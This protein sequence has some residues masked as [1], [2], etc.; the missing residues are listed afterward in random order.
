MS[1]MILDVLELK[2][3][4]EFSSGYSKKIYGRNIS[5]KLKMNQKTVSNVLNKLERKHVLKFNQVGRNKYYFLN[6]YYFGIKEI[7]N[8][9]EISRKLHFLEE[10]KKMISLFRKLESRANGMMIVFGSYADGSKTGKSDLDLFII[11]KN[12]DVEDL[13]A[14]YGVKINLIKSIKSKFNENEVI[15][16]EVIRNHVVLKGVEDF[17]NLIW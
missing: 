14:E 11:G 2:I 6:K 4:S 15:V 9:I 3:L 12:F 10:N 5:N 1:N 8:A 7:L 16:K 13:E 17:V